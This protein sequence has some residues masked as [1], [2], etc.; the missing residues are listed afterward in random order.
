M[1]ES[2]AQQK[3]ICAFW[4]SQRES[5]WIF[6]NFIFQ[7]AFEQYRAMAENIFSKEDDSKRPLN[8]NSV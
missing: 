1:M 3:K 6:K 5:G 2:Q 8:L 4:N 7:G